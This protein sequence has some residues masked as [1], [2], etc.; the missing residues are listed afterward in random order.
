MAKNITKSNT[1]K[2]VRQLSNK[3]TKEEA[4]RVRDYELFYIKY[5]EFVWGSVN[6]KLVTEGSVRL[7]ISLLSTYREEGT[8]NYK[9]MLLGTLDEFFYNK[10]NSMDLKSKLEDERVSK[11]KN[12]DRKR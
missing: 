8:G 3:L 10:L 12:L 1:K 4:D 11:V 5:N 2:I 7:G 9:R 6:N